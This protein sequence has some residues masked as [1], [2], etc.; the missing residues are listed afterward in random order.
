MSIFHLTPDKG[1]EQLDALPPSHTRNEIMALI[2]RLQADMETDDPNATFTERVHRHAD[3][4][5]EL[6][7]SY[8]MLYRTV[9]K[10]YVTPLNAVGIGPMK[11]SVVSKDQVLP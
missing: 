3:N 10:P 6:F 9:I 5:K 4:H 7:F 11:D 1:G 8:P 2:E